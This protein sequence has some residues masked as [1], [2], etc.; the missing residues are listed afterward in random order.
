M[1][2]I[3]AILE[4]DKP[5]PAKQKHTAKRIFD[6]LQAEHGFTGGYTTVK[7]YV[8]GEH[9]R[10]REMFVPLAHTPGEAQ[11]DFPPQQQ[12]PVA[13][14]P[15]FGEALVIVAGVECKAHYLVMDLPHSDDCFVRAMPAETTEAFLPPHGRGPVRGGPGLKVTCKPSGI[16][17]WCRRAFCMTTPRLQWPRSWAASS[18]RGRAL[19]L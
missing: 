11:A 12:G 4:D 9:V 17:V 14:T 16:S 3:D 8:R 1:G 7:K 2:V 13:G 19:F 15:D 18:G 5:K 10:G 6:Q